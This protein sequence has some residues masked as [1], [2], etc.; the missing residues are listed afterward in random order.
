MQDHL[1]KLRRRCPRFR[2]WQ[3]VGSQSVRELAERHDKAYQRFFAYKRGEGPRHGRPRFKKVKTYSSFTFKQAGWKYDGG[4]R[5]I[6]HGTPY[7]FSFSRPVEGDIKTVT[8]KR[9]RVGHLWI[10]F[11]V[12]TEA[13]D[14]VGASTGKSGGFD[15]GLRAFLTDH[16]GNEYH[17][18]QFLKDELNE[19]ARLSRELSRKQKGSNSWRKAKWRLARAHVRLVNK[20]RDAHWKLARDLCAR[21]DLICLETLNLEGMKRLWGE[22]LTTWTLLSLWASCIRWPKRPA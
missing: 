13:P 1:A 22:K 2:H 18:P 19:I 12:V 5:V 10:C 16:K 7:K 9:D 20:R 6:I 15:F 11:S 14:P 4:N 8:V 3:L 17:S 21:F